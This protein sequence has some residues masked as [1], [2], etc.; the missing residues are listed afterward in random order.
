MLSKDVIHSE[1]SDG[2][3]EQASKAQQAQEDASRA[4]T[5]A[6]RAKLLAEV[7]KTR[8]EQIHQHALCKC[9]HS[10]DIS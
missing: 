4:A 1:E 10:N 7:S 2:L 5:N 9:V 3:I 8:L 6:A